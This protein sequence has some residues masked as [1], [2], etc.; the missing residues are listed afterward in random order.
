MINKNSLQ[1]NQNPTAFLLVVCGGNP[2]IIDDA[3]MK[4]SGAFLSPGKG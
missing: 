3:N 1:T 2:A 4:C